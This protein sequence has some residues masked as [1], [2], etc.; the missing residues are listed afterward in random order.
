MSAQ[1]QDFE[2]TEIAIDSTE[3]Q[4]RTFVEPKL[5]RHQSLPKITAGFVGTFNP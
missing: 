4:P 2:P 3:Q 5:T 1:P